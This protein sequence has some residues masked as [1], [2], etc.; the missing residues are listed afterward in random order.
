MLID[1]E[2]LTILKNVQKKNGVIELP[3]N[4]NSMYPF[5]QK[6]D[7]CHFISCNPQQLKKGD[8]VLFY[9]KSGH[10]IA[11]RFF[12]S[13]SINQEEQY[14]LKGDTNLGFDQPVPSD[15]IIGKL[16]KIQR[17]DKSKRVN[18]FFAIL[19]GKIIVYLPQ[20]SSMLQRYLRLRNAT[21]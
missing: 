12:Y 4:G 17:N 11:H 3:A 6:G 13:I 18:N 21:I 14:H 20:L 2:V 7:V 19:W 10:L 9:S 8:V 15:N 16:D 5:I 1:K